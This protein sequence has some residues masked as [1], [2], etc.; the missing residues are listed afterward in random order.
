[1]HADPEF[2]TGVV[3]ITP[4][5]DPNDYEVGMRHDLPRVKVINPDA[6]MNENAGIYCG[7]SREECRKKL[8]KDLE[9]AGILIS[10][11]EITHSVGHSER[12]DAIVEPYLSRQ[13][14][15]KMRPLAD[16]VLENQKNKNTKV[17][18]VPERF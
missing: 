6:T 13:W 1:M 15:V 8:V 5:H 17:N 14:F 16:R 3:K 9:E 18:F 10:V 11:E 4:A 12:S 7:L 2:G